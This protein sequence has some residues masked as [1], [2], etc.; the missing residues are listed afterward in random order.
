MI[1]ITSVQFGADTEELVLGVLR[2]G[3]IAQGPMVARFESEFAELL[4]VEHA[5]AVS[6]GTVSLL[7]ALQAAGV[8]PGSEVIT[9]PF[10]FVATINAAVHVGA[11]VRFADIEPDT[12]CLDPSALEPVRN[13]RTAALMPVHIFGQP[14]DMPGLIATAGE[15]TLMIEDA[16]Q[17]HGAE[18]AERA[19]GTYGIGSFSF[20]ATKN[21]TTGEGG[22]VTT[23][24]AAI[25]DTVR[26][27]S[28]QG[29]RARYQ[30][31]MPGYNLRL[32]DLQAA[33]GVSQL[34]GYDEVLRRRRANAAALTAGLADVEGCICPTVADGRTH[35]WH[36][37]TIRA[38]GDAPR[39][40]DATVEALHAAGIGAGVYY[41]KLAWDYDCFSGH[42][43]IVTDPTP[44]AAEVVGQ[45][46]SLPVHAALTDAEIDQIITETR[47]VF[48]C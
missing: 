6:N 31:E 27:L 26:L 3:H 41:P 4:G 23:N 29:M 33:V 24:D 22:M 19:A 32:T 8:G 13:E 39:S 38:T 45:V 10:T 1:P 5:V 9:S 18:V 40:R 42:P 30:Y 34:A 21:L 36:Q 2:S 17:A 44:I 48:G 47:K 43:R 14:A 46:I 15:D 7:A 25:A 28:N 16:A 37:Y 20:Y 35:V 12:M 11:T